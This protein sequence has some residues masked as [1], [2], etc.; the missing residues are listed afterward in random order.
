VSVYLIV[1]V[2]A[3]L[4]AFGFAVAAGVAVLRNNKEARAERQLRAMP[5]T[6]PATFHYDES[7]TLISVRKGPAKSLGDQPA[8]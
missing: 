8:A 5:P 4:A 1:A 7:G 2:L 6:T 3:V